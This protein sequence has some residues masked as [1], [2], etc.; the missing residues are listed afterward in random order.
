[1][2]N[3]ACCPCLV[4]KKV[5]D[6]NFCHVFERFT[7]STLVKGVFQKAE[8]FNIELGENDHLAREH[9]SIRHVQTE[10]I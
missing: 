8:N 5:N 10:K 3:C 2:A 6:R 1:M 9:E 4:G 7:I